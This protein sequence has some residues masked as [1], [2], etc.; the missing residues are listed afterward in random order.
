MSD[1]RVP[2][3]LGQRDCA[4]YRFWVRHPNTGQR[5]LGYIGETGRMPFQRLMEHIY[6]QPWA[7]T[8]VGWEVDPVTHP[9][10]AAVLA[11]EKTAIERERPLYNIEGN[12]ANPSRIPPW[13]AVQQRQARQ[14][15]WQP[16]QKGEARIPRQRTARRAPSR[17]VPSSAYARWWQRRRATVTVWAALW[18]ALWA[19]TWWAGSDAWSG[20]DE[21]RNAAAGAT[22]LLAVLAWG[23]LRAADQA[24]RN[25]RRRARRRSRR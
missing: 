23:Y 19:L 2:S 7:D 9:G 10:K 12:M 14:P 24:R 3:S 5:A 17:V 8:I 21:P 20:W 11:A 15:G 18:L 6:Q 25:R 16:P 13:T 4:L 1:R 22:L